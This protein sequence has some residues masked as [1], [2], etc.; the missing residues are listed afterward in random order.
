[1]RLEDRHGRTKPFPIGPGY[2]IDGEPVI[3]TPPRREAPTGETDK[4]RDEVTTLRERLRALEDQLKK[5]GAT[6]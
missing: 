6:K 2:L 3:L 4:L 5:K 1:M